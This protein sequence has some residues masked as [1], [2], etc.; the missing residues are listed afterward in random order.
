[1]LVPYR[2]NTI[3]GNQCSRL[4]TPRPRKSQSRFSDIK[5]EQKPLLHQVPDN[6][7]PT[8]RRHRL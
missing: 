3:P 1:M 8:R 2:I 7:K 6:R 5:F 4:R